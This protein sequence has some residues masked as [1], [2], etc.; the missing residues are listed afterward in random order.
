MDPPQPPSEPVAQDVSR[1]RYL[2]AAGSAA[3]AGSA[4][5]IREVRS[6]VTRDNPDQVS[7]AI[8]TTPADADQRA[9]R[10]ARFLAQRLSEVG[11]R[12]TI[13]PMSRESLYRDVLLNHAFQ[14][15]VAPFPGRVDPDFLRSLLH[16]RFATEPGWQ[17]PVGYANLQVDDLLDRQ[18]RETG[19]NRR[20]TLA[21]IQQAVARDQPFTVVGFPDEIRGVRSDSFT[22]W[23]RSSV[24]SALGYLGLDPVEGESAS[25]DAAEGE[26][27]GRRLRMTLTDS[28]P[29]ENLNPIAVEARTG[30]RILDLVYDPLARGVDGRIRPWMAESVDWSGASETAATVTLRPDLTWHDGEPIT[31]EDVA[32]TYEFLSDTSLGRLDSPVPSPRFRGRSSLV[33]DA[34]ALD[35]RRVRLTFADTARPVAATSL[36][37]PVLPRHVWKEMAVQATVAGVDV[38]GGVTRALV[39]GNPDPVGSGPYR[40]A[41]RTPSASLKLEAAEDHFLRRENLESH[42]RPYAGDPAVD[43]LVFTLVPS[44]A[45]AVEFVDGGDADGTASDLTAAEVPEIGRS[46][47]MELVVEQPRSFYHVGYNLRRAPTSSPRFRRAVARLVDKQYLVESVFGGY[48]EPAASPLARHDAMDP[49]LAWNGTDPELPFAGDSGSLD[50]ERA[51]EAF[52]SAGYRYSEDGTLLAS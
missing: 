51:R 37:I 12:A 8:K 42:L 32:F 20:R 21:S 47:G 25:A 33:S 28:R 45:A 36:T 11:I 17:N 26:T 10:I 38:G 6:L 48:G 34:T 30:G 14:L 49:S 1:R 52:R 31:A 44:P 9:I 19:H 13:T 43:R 4:G 40:V 5:C 22:G 29:T 16:S 2:G 23:Q 3:L 35:E 39:W 7:L 41:G 15:Y 27:E 46:D 24:H 18:R 50:V